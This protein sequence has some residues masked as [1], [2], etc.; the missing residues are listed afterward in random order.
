MYFGKKN[1]EILDV[2]IIRNIIEIYCIPKILIYLFKTE[3]ISI[4]LI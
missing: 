3:K 1:P 4:Y 2:S